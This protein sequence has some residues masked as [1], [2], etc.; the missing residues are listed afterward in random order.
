MSS[1][2][3]QPIIVPPEIDAEMTPAVRAFVASLI[4]RIEKLEA[5]LT[6]SPQNSSLPP[7]SQ[8]PHA[9]PPRKRKRV[10]RENGVVS[11]DIRD[12]SGS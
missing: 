10:R 1:T 7:S 12:I 6:L 2:M 3:A 5:R 9:K 8:H 11:R 4:G